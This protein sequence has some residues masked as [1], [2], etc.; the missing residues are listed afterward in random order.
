MY[1][2]RNFSKNAICVEYT[3]QR[4]IQVLLAKAEIICT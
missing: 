4:E 2:A 1:K 3:M